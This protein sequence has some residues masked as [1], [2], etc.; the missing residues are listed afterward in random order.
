MKK[1][2]FTLI[3]L[4]VTVAVLAVLMSMVVSIL[5]NV[6]KANVKSAAEARLDSSVSR[7]L[8]I[9]KRS[10]RAS[11]VN[12]VPTSLE[13]TVNTSG[14]AL[15][16]NM[17]DPDVNGEVQVNF[18]YNAANGT[19]YVNDPSNTIGENIV[20]CEFVV[21]D[22]R[23]YETTTPTTAQGVWVTNGA[24]WYMGGNTLVRVTL[25]A[26]INVPGE[27]AINRVVSDTVITRVG[28]SQ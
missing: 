26:R 28:V 18:V 7:T 9:I 19:I 4:L 14:D 13:P 2:G 23:R 21:G 11:T 1:N 8:E 5:S 16:V 22:A 24:V 3:E 12:I 27:G 25:T 10:V 15:T 6:N 17:Y 20:A